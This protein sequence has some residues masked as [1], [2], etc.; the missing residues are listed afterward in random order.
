MKRINLEL[1]LDAT[2]GSS[3]ASVWQWIC[4]RK[5][6]TVKISGRVFVPC[7]ADRIQLTTKE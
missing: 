1:A 7:Q 2:L 6:P 3:V 4:E 5:L